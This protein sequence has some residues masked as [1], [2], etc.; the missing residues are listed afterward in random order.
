MPHEPSLTGPRSVGGRPGL[1][2][3][4]TAPRSPAQPVV[5]GG[6]RAQR[7][8]CGNRAQGET[9]ATVLW[10]Q[11]GEAGQ[12]DLR[13]GNECGKQPTND[14][15]PWDLSDRGWSSKRDE[16]VY[17]RNQ[18]LNASSAPTCSTLADMG[19]SVSIPGLKSRRGTPRLVQIP[20]VTTVKGCGVA[21]PSGRAAAAMGSRR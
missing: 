1:G 6:L 14:G 5:D 15:T 9:F 18:R 17:V 20:S 10:Q 8:R 3:H 12:P 16:T 13:V 21:E 2:D 19:W 11:C 7:G 4:A